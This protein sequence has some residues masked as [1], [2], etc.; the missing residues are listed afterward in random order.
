M[1]LYNQGDIIKDFLARMNQSSTSA[2]YTDDILTN[3][4]SNANQWAAARY[5]WPMTEGRYSTTSASLGT[6][7]DGFTTLTY[8]EGFRADSIRL[9][10][11]G[12]KRFDKKIFIKFQG[13]LQDNPAD[14]SDIYSDFFR[15]IVINPN[16]KD[17]SG[18]VVA[19]GQV[20]IPPLATDTV[21]SVT[22]TIGPD[23]TALTIFSGTEEDGNEAIV[24]KMM[25]Y[26]YMRERSPVGLQRGKLVSASALHDQNASGILDAIWK[27]IQDEQAMYQ[28]TRSDSMFERFDV[29]GGVLEED[30]FRRDQWG[31]LV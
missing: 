13:F 4:C 12:G 20:N 28:T 27:R 30:A 22:G 26:A 8:P 15:T 19:W 21:G 11:I 23:P 18:T 25:A 9:L 7:E 3:W 6:N 24:Q 16:A 17:L 2:F 5:K 14:T 10:T 1:A 31:G 29:V